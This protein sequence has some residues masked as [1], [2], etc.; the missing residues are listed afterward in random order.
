MEYMIP[1]E[2]TGETSVFPG[3]IEVIVRILPTGR[4][5]HPPVVSVHVR[6]IGMAAHITVVGRP[7][8]RG[9]R[10]PALRRWTVGGDVSAADSVASALRAAATTLRDGRN[11]ER[12]QQRHHTQKSG[13]NTA[14]PASHPPEQRRCHRRPVRKAREWDQRTE[15]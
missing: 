2:A 7:R 11:R 13:H 5:P 12:E 8:R 6:R 14:P 15:R 3:V 1:P 9:W 4:M 10:T